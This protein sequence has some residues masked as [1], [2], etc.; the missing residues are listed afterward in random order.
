GPQYYGV[1]DTGDLGGGSFTVPANVS[2]Y[3]AL[4]PEPGGVGMVLVGGMV[5]GRRRTRVPEGRG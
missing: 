2:Y 1:V 5:V 3:F 4:A